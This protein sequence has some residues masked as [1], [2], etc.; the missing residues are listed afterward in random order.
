MSEFPTSFPDLDA[1]EEFMTRPDQALVD[2]L[3]ALEGDILILGGRR[4][5]G[6]DHGASCKTRRPG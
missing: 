5:D 3:A 4:Q 2:D 6:P 1:V